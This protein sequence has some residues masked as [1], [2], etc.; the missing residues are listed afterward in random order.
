V[1]PR[2]G[3][4]PNPPSILAI[5]VAGIGD[6][7]LGVPALRALRAGFPDAHIALLGRYPPL[8]LLERCPYVDELL[9]LD[10]SRFKGAG[11]LRPGRAGAEL[12]RS[13]IPLRARR[14]ALA[15]NLY[16]IGTPA[17]GLR[18]AALLAWAGAGIT[19]GRRS[20]FRFPRYR[21]TAEGAAHELE[22]QLTVVQALGAP[23]SGTHLELWIT[24]AHREACDAFLRER[25]IPADARIACLHPGST[26]LEARYPLSGFV[27]VA[28]RLAAAGSRLVVTGG[29]E[30]RPLAEAL[31][32]AS[33]ARPAVAAGALGLGALG[34][35]FQRADLLVTNDSGPMHL[36]AAAGCPLLALFGPTD[37]TAFG[38]RGRPE[39]TR[40]LA[41]S[42][43]SP[44]DEAAWL[45][46]LPPARVAAE[47]EAI[48]DRVAP[49]AAR[50][51]R[52]CC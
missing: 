29:P 16:L 4:I 37:P 15:V 19:A 3:Q 9:A 8:D 33:R 52:E 35:L 45:A 32:A 48:L 25:G 2:P 41:A 42:C 18:M 5:L 50:G 38:P 34:A 7:V 36:A 31:A 13:V 49:H 28:D 12:A 10:L 44:W 27:A 20:P 51:A 43:S 46:A 11:W 23:D 1:A 17:G 30:E 24:R 6:I 39:V 40:V 22:S 26:K 21:V 14:F 47:A